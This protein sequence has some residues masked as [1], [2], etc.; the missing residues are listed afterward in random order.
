[1]GASHFLWSHGCGATSFPLE[2][3]GPTQ[4]FEAPSYGERSVGDGLCDVS[5]S[6]LSAPDSGLQES[7]GL[8]SSG[9]AFWPLGAFGCL[10]F[11]IARRAWKACGQSFPAR[12]AAPPKAIRKAEREYDRETYKRRNETERLFWRTK[13][14]RRIFTRFDKLD[15]KFPGSLNLPVVVEMMYDS[16]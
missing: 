2:E 4:V 9:T 1:M 15:A 8:F 16:A 11:A 14:C 12:P 13:G 5:G 6:D 7:D 3:A 10:A